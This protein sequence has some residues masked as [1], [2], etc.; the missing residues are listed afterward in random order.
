MEWD[1]STARYILNDEPIDEDTLIG[2]LDEI[3]DNAI[4]TYLATLAGM[5]EAG[6]NPD[7][8]YQYTVEELIANYSY[9]YMLGRGG[10][11]QMTTDDWAAVAGAVAYQIG[12]LDNFYAEVLGMSQ[13]AVQA[14]SALYLGAMRIPFFE[15]LSEAVLRSGAYTQELWDLDFDAEHCV[16]CVAYAAEGWQALG[17]W[18]GVGVYPGSGHT[19]CLGNCRCTIRFR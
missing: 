4:A 3:I 2:L 14:R 1:E 12:Y 10:R 11:E 17:R 18:T 15:G 13:A 9:T 5:Y 6:F 19:E 8:W 16:D 7:A